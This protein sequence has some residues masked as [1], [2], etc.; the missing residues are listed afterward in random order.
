MTGAHPMRA[1]QEGN[2][3]FLAA[4][5]ARGE[6]YRMFAQVF[7]HPADEI[8]DAFADGSLF[9]TLDEIAAG[10]PYPSPFR[11]MEAEALPPGIMPEDVRIFYSSTF[12]VGNPPVSMRETH[13]SKKGEKTLFEE[14]LRYYQHFGLKIDSGTLR[15]WPDMLAVELEF[16]AY[17]ASLQASLPAHAEALARARSDFLERHLA[18]WAGAFADRLKALPKAFLYPR[19]A[20]YLVRFLDAEQRFCQV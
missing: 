12:E 6:L 20:E 14:L 9:D 13:Y 7:S 5:D 11:D 3:A 10:L 15:E 1:G 17:L 4:A 2:E 19:L 16:M 8:L 18:V